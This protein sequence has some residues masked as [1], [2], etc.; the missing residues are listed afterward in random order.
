MLISLYYYMTDGG[1][2][3]LYLKKDGGPGDLQ[4]FTPSGQTRATNEHVFRFTSMLH[5]LLSLSF[6]QLQRNT[7]DRLSRLLWYMVGVHD[8]YI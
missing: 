7:R 8:M 4:F 6:A 1:C 3:G 5:K 2:A